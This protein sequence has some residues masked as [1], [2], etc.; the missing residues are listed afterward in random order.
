[1]IWIIIFYSVSANSG[2]PLVTF[3]P[4]SPNNITLY[5]NTSQSIYYKVTNQSSIPHIFT[6]IGLPTGFSLVT[7]G[8]G[9]CEANFSLEGGA[10]CLLAYK[11]SG[12]TLSG[13][14]SY[15]PKV[16]QI[17]PNGL[18]SP[19][20]CYQ[21]ASSDAINVSY[22]ASQ[23]DSYLSVST[24]F[25]ALSVN[26]PALNPAL[27]GHTRYFTITNKGPNTA[28]YVRYAA[29]TPIPTNTQITD[30]CNSAPLGVNETCQISI[31]PGS[32]PNTTGSALV[33]PTI[34]L[35]YGSN[36]N[37]LIPSFQ[38]FTYKNLYQST[39][40]YSI[41]DNND[42]DKSIGGSGIDLINTSTAINWSNTYN[43]VPGVTFGSS[44]N[45]YAAV[46]GKC[47]TGA[48]TSFYS[49]DLSQNYAAA[50]CENKTTGG[51]TD[52][53]LPAICELGYGDVVISGGAESCGSSTAPL[54][55]NVLSAL[56]NDVSS[57]LLWSS[58]QS[59]YIQSGITPT[60][61]SLYMTVSLLFP[62]D[63]KANAGRIKAGCV[64]NFTPPP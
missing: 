14:A 25:I 29:V 64:R 15:Q 2:Q 19:Y 32:T 16:C 60:T 34:L 42:L 47:N 27:T 43:D 51:Y 57:Y 55:Q 45:C 59:A 56:G 9:I 5:S 23:P 44:S 12:T 31:Q 30:G 37:I 49:S 36:T 54:T 40:I 58:T 21:A 1:M 35:V 6:S 11:V 18:P 10:S 20:L 17:A 39:Y 53:Y 24:D 41:I 8:H 38:V 48:I 52:W 61:I 4:L 50:Y 22:I 62:Q 63:K 26:D 46:D 13:N 3:N 7:S 28:F 33:L